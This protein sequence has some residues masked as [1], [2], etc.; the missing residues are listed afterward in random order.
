MLSKSKILL[1]ISLSSSSYQSH[2]Y[3]WIYLFPCWN[4]VFAPLYE[5]FSIHMPQKILHALSLLSFVD[6]SWSLPFAALGDVAR[7]LTL[8]LVTRITLG[9]CSLKHCQ[10]STMTFVVL[11]MA[12]VVGTSVI[13]CWFCYLHCMLLVMLSDGCMLYQFIFH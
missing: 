6:S 9:F 3:L 4:F 13:L 10:W 11:P 1:H 8:P 2:C 5:I 12:V 7:N